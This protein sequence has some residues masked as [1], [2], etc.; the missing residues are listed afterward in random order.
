[1]RTP[2]LS[3]SRRL[4]S[5]AFMGLCLMLGCTRAPPPPLGHAAY[6]WQRDW[7]PS[8]VESL[9]RMPPELGALRVLA[10]ERSGDTR[11]PVSIA[12]DVAALARTGRDVVAVMRVDGTAPLDGISLE[13]VAAIARDWKARGVRVRGVELD[14]D[15]ATTALPAYAD[16]LARERRLLGELSLS[17]TALPTWAGAPELERLTSIPDDVVV[18]VHAIRAPTLFTPEEARGFIERWSQATRRPFHVALPT[19]RVRLRDGTP[20][21]SEPREVSRFLAQLRARPVQGVK[22]L[23][24]FRWGHA[25]DSEA[26]SPSTLTAVLRQE[27]LTL[28]VE[29]RLVDAGGGT[30]DI[31][32]ENTGRLDGEAPARLTLSGNLEVLDG[33]GGYAPRGSSLVARKPPRLRAGERRVVGFVR[34]SEVSLVAP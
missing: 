17:I 15:C 22:G 16:W 7:S 23:V 4:A 32:L 18:Q 5:F 1:M 27:P 24:W 21:V 12:V 8:L 6:V 10:R 28:Q 34:G 14:H 33:V 31:V 9:T 29:S 3:S 20:L 30:L 26:W 13:E 11:A 2:F 25:G 19:Y